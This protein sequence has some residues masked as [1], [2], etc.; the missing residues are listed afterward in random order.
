MI[1][2]GFVTVVCYV[3]ASLGSAS[4]IPPHLG[5]FLGIVLG[6]TLVAH[7]ANRWLAPD[8]NPVIL[9]I[10]ALLNGIGYVLVAE[11][12][13]P[14]EHFPG[15]QAAW[16]AVGIG[17][18]VITLAVI[19]HSRD[20]DR[21]RYL[22]LLVGAFLLLTPLLPVI[23]NNQYGARL[24][25]KLGPASFQPVEIAKI[26]LCIFFASYFAEKKE[27]LS[28]PT[29]RVGNRLFLDPWPL[30]PILVAWGF[31][32]LVIGVENDIG[33]ASLLFVLFIGMLWITTGRVA[34]LV[35]GVVLFVA[36]AVLA[37]HLFGQ[38][39]ERVSIWLDPWA[40]LYGDGEQLAYGWFALGTGGVGGLG[41]GVADGLEPIPVPFLYSDMIFA[42]VGEALGLLGT[43]TVA[44]AFLLLV[45]AGF[46]VAQAARSDFAKLMATGLTILLGFQ[47]LFI[48]AGVLRLLPL[49]GITLPF[50]AYGGSSLVANYVLIA[51][52]MRISQ[53]GQAASA[54]GGEAPELGGRRFRVAS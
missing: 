33:F 43:A 1:M 7:V 10:A 44:M 28:V 11:F 20:L 36:G 12:N 53:E 3:L 15:L 47:A 48:M 5:L 50:M 30:I 29:A 6:L 46:R 54:L 38:V 22:L 16:T 25:I 13:L 8:A 37:A 45:G 9:P 27:M 24:W 19:R 51:L 31:A 34:Y 39:H 14:G 52:L 49:T 41:L 26:L 21:Y 17:A 18:Y 42:G 2:T 32:M 23:G 35:L 40:H 4:H